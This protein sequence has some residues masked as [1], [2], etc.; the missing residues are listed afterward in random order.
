[1]ADSRDRR[2]GGD[3]MVDWTRQA[4]FDFGTEVDALLT[5]QELGEELRGARRQVEE[6]MRY[7]RAAVR[8]A[9]INGEGM[10]SAEAIIRESGLSRR[11]VY[12]MLEED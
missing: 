6:T 9:R 1:M 12:K 7:L 11:T 3:S 8:A 2:V 4:E 5:L 10:T